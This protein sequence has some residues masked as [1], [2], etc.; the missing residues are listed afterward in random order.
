MSQSVLFSRVSFGINRNVKLFCLGMGKL[1]DLNCSLSHITFVKL[2]IL[3]IKWE[4][5]ASIV[6]RILES[7]FLYLWKGSSSRNCPD[8]RLKIKFQLQSMKDQ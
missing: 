6:P 1:Y 7:Q 5:G 3:E 8:L 2:P 4:K